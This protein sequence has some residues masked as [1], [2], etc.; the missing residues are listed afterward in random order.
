MTIKFNLKTLS[1]ILL[2]PL[3]LC[4]LYLSISIHEVSKIID[5]EMLAQIVY[6]RDKMILWDNKCQ[7]GNK[8][9]IGYF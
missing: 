9:Q 6:I 4:S 5:S 7:S 3:D 8:D 1:A 2:V